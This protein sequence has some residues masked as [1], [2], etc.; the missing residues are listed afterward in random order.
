LKLIDNKINLQG[1]NFKI[2]NISTNINVSNYEILSKMQKLMKKKVKLKFKQ[3]DKR[4][5][6]LPLSDGE[7]GVLLPGAPNPVYL[8]NKVN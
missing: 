3:A 7:R 8:I 6:F 4:E 1:N 2:F 5:N